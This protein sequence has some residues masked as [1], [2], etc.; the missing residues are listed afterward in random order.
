MCLRGIPPKLLVR[1][2]IINT[3][4]G[5]LFILHHWKTI[6][7]YDY[8]KV[9]ENDEQALEEVKG[10]HSTK[11]EAVVRTLKRQELIILNFIIS[12]SNKKL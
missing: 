5:Y 7:Y 12:M 11:V 10:S 3:K 1:L 2:H 6:H 4:D 9:E 8:Y